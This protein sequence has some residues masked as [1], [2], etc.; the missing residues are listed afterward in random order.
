MVESP[1]VLRRGLLALA[2]ALPY[3]SGTVPQL[4]GWQVERSAHQAV[5]DTSLEAGVRI[6]KGDGGGHDNIIV[7]L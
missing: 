1:V 4:T 6:T 2:R 5:N 7:I 3:T